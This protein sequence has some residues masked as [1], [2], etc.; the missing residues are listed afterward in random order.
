MS[1]QQL[2]GLIRSVAKSYVGWGLFEVLV[3]RTSREETIGH[4]V[5]SKLWKETLVTG[6]I[7]LGNRGKVNGVYQ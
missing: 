1:P 7:V 5:E 6:K 2:V 3:G 4:G